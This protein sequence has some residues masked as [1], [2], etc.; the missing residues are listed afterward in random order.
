MNFELSDLLYYPVKSLGAIKAGSIVIDAFGV[1]ND[2]RF[3]LIDKNNE[4]VTQRKYP[5]L[6]L[7][8]ASLSS[9]SLFISG[10]DLGR[11]EFA[12]N[13][14]SGV[15]KVK[16]WDDFV[17]AEIIDDKL[18]AVLSDYVGE[19]VRLAYIPDKSYRQVDRNFFAGDQRVSFADGFPLL[20][21]NNASLLDL[22]QKLDKPVGM[23]RF[24]S[25]IVFSGN[26]AFQEDVWEQVRIGEVAF[27]L[28]KPCGRCNMT[29]INSLGEHTKEPLKALS[30]Y[31]KNE[32]GVC[33]G[34]NMVQMNQGT[35]TM[36]DKL[37][38][39]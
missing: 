30:S 39:I 15:Q 37:S 8:S 18:T 24:R 4:F 13:S 27:K 7:L 22:N 16:I 35:I 6:S 10:G 3:M 1:K 23:H 31:R 34:Q 21:T 36:G 2:R 9:R 19:S 14:L 20:L 33:F 17:E 26:I 29:T 5:Q 32:F 12:L 38:V 11:L 25:N 28:V